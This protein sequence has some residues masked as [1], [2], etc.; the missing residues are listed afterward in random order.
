MC[1][2]GTENDHPKLSEP[3]DGEMLPPNVSDSSASCAAVR[4]V[5][6][7]IAVRAR[8]LVRPA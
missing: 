8:I 6:P 2:D 4:R 3:A 7:L 1:C 5:V